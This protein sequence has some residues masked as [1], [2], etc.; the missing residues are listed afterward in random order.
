MPAQRTMF[1]EPHVTISDN[2]V[3]EHAANRLLLMVERDRELLTGDSV[4][5]IDRR[6][7]AEILWEDGVQAIL[8]ASSK[9]TFIK[10]VVAAQESDVYSRARRWLVE[11]DY[12]R[13]PAK[14]I[15]QAERTRHRIAGAMR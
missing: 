9:E 1:D 4:G 11:H 10:T 5:I 8:P 6:L 15:Q 7:Y 2:P 13:L 14:A 3:L 12:I